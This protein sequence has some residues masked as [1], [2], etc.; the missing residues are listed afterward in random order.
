MR[1]EGAV[2]REAEQI[3]WTGCVRAVVDLR[4]LTHVHF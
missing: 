1:E 4:N 2:K 3:G